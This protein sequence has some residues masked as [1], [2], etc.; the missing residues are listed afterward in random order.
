M[1]FIV[2]SEGFLGKKLRGVLP[3]NKII[4]ISSKK[5]KSCIRTKV[6]SVTKKNSSQHTEK[7][8]KRIS[9]KDIIILLSNP[10]SIVFSEKYPKKLMYFE[11]NL[12]KNFFCKVNKDAKIIFFSSDMVYSGNKSIYTDKSVARPI[13]NYGKSKIRLENKIKKYFSKYLILRFS[14]IFSTDVNDKTIYS[15]IIES[16]KKQ[17]YIKLFSNQY[18]H[19]LDVRDF[20]RGF[21]KITTKLNQI[22][23][24]FN[25]PGKKFTTRYAF[26][27]KICYKKKLNTKYI[28][29]IKV[30]DRKIKLPLKL[31]MKTNLFN[32]INFFPQY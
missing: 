31:R 10:G 19:Y 6:F 14:K 4:R 22:N 26:T 24:T 25:F 1:Y 11:K 17:K 7:W 9:N 32:K 20:I 3:K 30:K 12:D 2:G 23:G 29:P 21:Q 5:K 13:N 16:I 15:E 18:V 27:K 28:I 8:I